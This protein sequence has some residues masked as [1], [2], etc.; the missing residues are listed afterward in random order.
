MRRCWNGSLTAMTARVTL[1]F[2]GGTISMSSA[3]GHAVRPCL[4]ADELLRA[5]PGL[6]ALDVEV[7]S[8]T[9]AQEQSGSLTFEHLLAVLDRARTD[10]ADGFVLVQGTDTLEESAYVVDLLWDD[11]RP[12]VATGAMRNPAM[13]GADGGANLLAA[14]RVAAAGPAH[15]LGAV[16]VFADEIHAARH[17]TKSDTASLTTFTSPKPGPIGRVLEGHVHL[18]HR[19]E[20]RP[21]LATP[22]RVPAEVPLVLVGLAQSERLLEVVAADADALIIAGLG[23]GHVPGW[24]AESVGR[25]ASRIPVVMTSRAGAGP[26]LVE[27]YGAI[28]AEVDL[29]ARGVIMGGYL[30]PLKARLLVCLLLAGGAGRAAVADAVRL[31]GG[32]R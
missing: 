15:G 19:P 13:A 31:H 20:R 6:A 10:S 1:F 24:W 26:A 29:Q 2:L 14:I 28:G 22:A 7:A 3:D 18:F 9:I 23:A 32:Y 8:E 21:A 30:A 17:V 27:T 5:V 4:G 12:F 16:V 25:A 11:E